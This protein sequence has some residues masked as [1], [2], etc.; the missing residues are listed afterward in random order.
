MSNGSS[1]GPGGTNRGNALGDAADDQGDDAAPGAAA[2]PPPAPVVGSSVYGTGLPDLGSKE[3]AAAAIAAAVEKA[4]LEANNKRATMDALEKGLERL[5]AAGEGGDKD[6]ERSRAEME[7]YHL[8]QRGAA[9]LVTALMNNIALVRLQLS[10]NPVRS[11]GAMALAGAL[12]GGRCC[13][14]TLLLRDCKLGPECGDVL[15][16]VLHVNRTLTCLDLGSNPS[17]GSQAIGSI[18]R[19]LG[20][21]RGLRD[22]R[23]DGVCMDTASAIALARAL[24]PG[25][26]AA[27][28]EGGSTGLGIGFGFVP[29]S[30][31]RSPG[32]SPTRGGP[33]SRGAASVQ[34]QDGFGA[35][36]EGTRLP[37]SRSQSPTKGQ[38]SPR[39]SGYSSG[40]QVRPLSYGGG[41]SV[42]AHLDLRK[43]YIG[44]EGAQAL[45]AALAGNR[46]LRTL[47]LDDNCIETS[48]GLALAAALKVGRDWLGL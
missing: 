1:T 46:H 33:P 11:A 29:A 21:N 24:A 48:G 47:A 10:G 44:P 27:A 26:G 41:G 38:L 19:G 8:T 40:G 34:F 18:A 35:P 30:P 42:L 14:Q 17:L 43:N 36:G 45:A 13:L 32:A 4:V 28:L 7:S 22:L 25:P 15:G 23:L 16:S 39:G 5:N 12:A 6:K 37:G 3:A 31:T 9:A 20:F 2:A